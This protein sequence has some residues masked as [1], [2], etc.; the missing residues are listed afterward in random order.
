MPTISYSLTYAGVPFITNAAK[1]V[2]LPVYRDQQFTPEEH[3]PPRKHQP[4]VD[5]LDEVNR[6]LP[7]F[8]LQDYVPPP[9][10]PGRNQDA[11]ARRRHARRDPPLVRVGEWHY[12][13]GTSRWSVFRMLATSNMYK[14]M[15]AATTGQKPQTLSMQAVPDAPNPNSYQASNYLINSSMYMLPGRPLN[16]FG[17]TFDG[18]Y[19]VTLVD[20]RYWFQYSP[21]KVQ[22][23]G[24]TTWSALITQLAN[25]LGITVT[26]STIPVAYGTGPEPDSQLWVRVGNAGIL[27]DTVAASIGMVVARNLDGTYKLQS[28][29]DAIAAVTTNRGDGAK[30]VRVA[31]GDLFYS[32]S[33]LPAGDLTAARN[34]VIPRQVTVSFPKYVQGDDPVPHLLN[35]RYQ[36][37]R[38]SAWYEDSYGDSHGVTVGL[39]S[40]GLL[41]SGLVGTSG[42]HLIR[43]TA[44]ALYSGEVQARSGGTPLN[45][46]GLTSLAMQAAADY[47]AWQAAIPS[48]DEVYP[49]TYLWSPEGY[50]DL[51]WT[52]SDRDRLAAVRVFRAPWNGEADTMQHGTP[53]LANYTGVP[54]G[55]GG[56]SVAQTWYDQITSFG[57]GGTGAVIQSGDYSF[58]LSGSASFPQTFRWRGKINS[59]QT[60]EEVALFEGL[61]GGA[62]ANVVYRGIDG[63]IQQQHAAEASVYEIIP[64]QVFGTNAVKTLAGFRVSQGA[65]T[66]GGVSEVVLEYLSGGGGSTTVGSGSVTSGTIASGAVVSGT[67]ASGAIYPGNTII[68]SGGIASGILGWWSFAACSLS[69]IQCSG[70]VGPG[71]LASGAV[72]SGTIGSGVA[73]AVA[74]G[75]DVYYW[76]HDTTNGQLPYIRYVGGIID[77]SPVAS[78]N[79]HPGANTIYLTTFPTPRGGN[80]NTIGVY[81][82]TASTTSAGAR[83]GMYQSISDSNIY[84]GNLILDAGEINLATSGLV[85]ISINQALTAGAL[86]WLAFWSSTASCN[87]KGIATAGINPIIGV[88]SGLTPHTYLYISGTYGTYPASL[89]S[90]ALLGVSGAP[91]VVV[92]YNG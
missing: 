89:A 24:T 72:S 7:S 90:G 68:I 17:G 86:Y 25:A 71:A 66:S 12:P 83:L 91:A 81:V 13:T 88:N 10:D 78:P 8:Y 57:S 26:T 87:L 6:V 19:L 53:P 30:V 67:V 40:G 35:P 52:W 61:S 62:T 50:H 45:E 84:P 21:V 27:L 70:W 49:G 37:Q 14:A 5:L 22:P 77:Q 43:S 59:G 47:W 42:V 18:L 28:P 15:L 85:E 63:T 75:K 54:R 60:D 9:E 31:G 29:T 1:L 11:L 20:E 33:L 48:L 16:E 76:R 23:T 74:G 46:S 82:D 2:R 4:L 39:G 44:K 51:V 38:P 80:I 73:L 69:G 56:P 79:F 92:Q 32:G 41:T 3:E 64:H 58:T 65:W 34:S 36:N 55:V